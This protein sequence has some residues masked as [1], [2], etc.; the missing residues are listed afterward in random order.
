MGAFAEFERALIKER[1]QEGIE[2]AKKRGAF[3]GRQKSLS[4]EQVLNLHER[5][6]AGIT[7]AKITRELGVSRATIYNY[8]AMQIS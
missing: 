2:V 6:N 1:Q 8:S 4:N 5:L 3:K 7:K